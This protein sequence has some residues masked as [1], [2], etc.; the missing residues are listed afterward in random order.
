MFF[1]LF[2]F[3]LFLCIIWVKSIDI[4]NLLLYSTI[5]LIVLVG[6]LG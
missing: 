5:Y 6:Y 4:I 2:F 3:G 1:F